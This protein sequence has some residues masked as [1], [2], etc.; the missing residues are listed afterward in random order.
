MKIEGRVNTNFFASQVFKVGQ[1]LPMM[2]DGRVIG[3][4]TIT[5]VEGTYYMYEAEVLPEQTAYV[6]DLILGR[7]VPRYVMTSRDMPHTKETQMRFVIERLVDAVNGALVN[8]PDC[9]GGDIPGELAELNAA[10]KA[11]GVSAEIVD[12]DADYVDTEIGEVSVSM[13]LKA[14]ERDD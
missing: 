2:H 5:Q 14:G 9:L 4:S 10:I 13:H 11:L 8:D 1:Q 12:P 6:G 7:K 3:Q